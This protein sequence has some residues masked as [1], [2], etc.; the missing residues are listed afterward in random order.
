MVFREISHFLQVFA[1]KFTQTPKHGGLLEKVAR[2][3]QIDDFVRFFLQNQA[4]FATFCLKMD[5]NAETSWFP[6]ES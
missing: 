2:F 3:G 5:P 1:D 6:W 4:L